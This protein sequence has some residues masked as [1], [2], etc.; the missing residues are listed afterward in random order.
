MVQVVEWVSENYN[1]DS[2]VIQNEKAFNIFLFENRSP[3][4]IT[5]DDDCWFSGLELPIHFQIIPASSMQDLEFNIIS[6]GG[7]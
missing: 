7:N 2:T 5:C 1:K 6:F 3:N 4:T